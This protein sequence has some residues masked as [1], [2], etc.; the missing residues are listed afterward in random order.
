MAVGA[1]NCGAD[2][3]F[4]ASPGGLGF[5]QGLPRDE[6]ERLVREGARLAVRFGNQR[7]EALLL[8]ADG[9]LRASAGELDAAIELQARSVAIAEASGDA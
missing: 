2:R 5:H 1:D 8:S 4:S 3:H 9:G 6:A 7:V